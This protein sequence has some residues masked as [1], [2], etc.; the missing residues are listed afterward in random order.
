MSSFEDFKLNKQLLTAIQEAGLKEPT[1]I[2]K[3]AI[4]SVLSGQDVMGIAQTGTGKT[5][6]FALP[7][8]MNLKYAQGEDA[9]ALVLSP[10]RE[11]AIQLGEH[12]KAFSTYLDLRYVV[13]YGG[14]GPKQQ[15]E[16]LE[17]GVDIIISTPNR[18]MDLYLKGHIGARSIK[19][20]VMDEADKIMDM[21]FA[22]MIHR[23]LEVLPSKRQ[24]LLFSATMNPAVRR[25]A[26]NF[27]DFPVEVEVSEQATVAETIEQ[28]VYKVPNQGTKMKLLEDLLS[29]GEDFRRLIVFC[30]TRKQSDLVYEYLSRRFG[31]EDVRVIHANKG[32]NTRINAI[33]AFKSGDLRILVATDVA[34]RGIDVSDVSHVIN[35]DVP[36]IIEDYVHRVGRTGRAEREGKAITFCNPAEEYYIGKI[37]QLIRFKIPVELI[38]EGLV[39]EETPFSERQAMAREIDAQKK[40]EDPNF[41]GAFH[42]S[43]YKNSRPASSSSKRSARSRKNKR[44]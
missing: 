40:R 32:Q 16:E 31:E 11:L 1:E 10:T 3:K 24:N 42:E 6:A 14:V 5:A 28:L 34:A 23:I 29:D 30:R 44:R 12:F 4:P 41:Q 37:E 25:I 2:Q 7:I 22:G 8:L 17:S 33:N 43:K 20:L 18:F 19:V 35:F 21:G 39:V 26:D 15:I 27:L 36:I 9:R 38:D 13:L